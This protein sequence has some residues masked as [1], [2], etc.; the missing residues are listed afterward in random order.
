MARVIVCLNDA[1]RGALQELAERE[2]RDPRAQ[3]ALILRR[4][5]ERAGL[6]S[7]DPT[8]L[9]PKTPMPVT[10]QPAA[11]DAA[12]G[13][14]DPVKAE[15]LYQAT[16]KAFETVARNFAQDWFGVDGCERE[17]FRN[18]EFARVL[19]QWVIKR[20]NLRL[21]VVETVEINADE[22]GLRAWPTDWKSNSHWES[23]YD[24]EVQACF[25]ASIEHLDR[26]LWLTGT[27]EVAVSTPEETFAW[28]VVLAEGVRFL[29]NQAGEF[30]KERREKRKAEATLSS[31][32]PASSTAGDIQAIT[33]ADM[34]LEVLKQ[35]DLAGREM[36]V[37]QVKSLLRQ[38]REHAETVNRFR[39]K[40]ARP[41]GVND[42]VIVEKTIDEHQEQ[43]AQKSIRL[44]SVL[45]RLSGQ[46]IHVEAL[47]GE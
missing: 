39:E 20:D 37:E 27:R 38:L 21:V 40:A 15:Q 31:N 41:L 34:L 7:A 4:E 3:A 23:E 6:L 26:W 28:S 16:E 22:I 14:D 43:I 8:P 12:R 35:V 25:T 10:A 45:E 9:T 2:G 33:S 30:L 13:Q 47:T 18:V 29:F 5:L 19:G 36:E 44:R 42:Q 24:A 17:P 11:T 46:S 32:P 1:E